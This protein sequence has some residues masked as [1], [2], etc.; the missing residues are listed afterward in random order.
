MKTTS[1]RDQVIGQVHRSKV[2]SPLREHGTWHG[3]PILN[4]LSQH[5]NQV[6]RKANGTENHVTSGSSPS[7]TDQEPG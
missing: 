6:I 5:L 7:S 1:Y 3:S 4:K 2:P